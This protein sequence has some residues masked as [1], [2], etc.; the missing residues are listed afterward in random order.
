MRRLFAALVAWLPFAALATESETVRSPRA[1][2]S[3]VADQAAVAPGGTLMLGLR[4]RLAPGWHTYW[5]NAG[6]AGAPP[7][8]ALTLPE[9]A[10]A[11][12]I[13]WPAPERIVYGPLV[14]FGYHGEVLLPLRGD[15]AGRLPVRRHDAASRPS[16]TWLVCEEVCIPE[17]GR[18][19]A[20][21]ADRAPRRAPTPRRAPL[22][23][24]AEADRPRPSPW[25]ALG[26]AWSG[27]RQR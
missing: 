23:A 24:A 21:V 27:R 18:F 17:E 25:Q 22:F 3:L 19:R 5:R 20:R 13:T 2:V 10:A 15:P 11:G 4:M 14:N 12:P 26:G 9:G 16:A 6:D 7:E 1:S 8:I